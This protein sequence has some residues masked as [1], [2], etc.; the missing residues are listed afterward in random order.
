MIE[1]TDHPFYIGT[2]LIRNSNPAESSASAVCGLCQSG[3]RASEIE[4]KR[5]EESDERKTRI[6][7]PD[8]GAR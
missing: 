8:A 4:T 1:I 2:Q 5:K 3:G 6:V 7:L